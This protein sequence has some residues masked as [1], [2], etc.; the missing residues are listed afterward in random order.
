MIFLIKFFKLYCKT[1][2]IPEGC[3]EISTVDELAGAKVS[4]NAIDEG[5][6][7]VDEDSEEIS[8]PLVRKFV[9]LLVPAAAAATASNGLLLMLLLN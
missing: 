1:G 5:R 4:V 3:R 2:T 7:V 6:S 8:L 9:L